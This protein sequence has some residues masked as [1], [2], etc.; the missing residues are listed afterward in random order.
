[1]KLLLAE[2]IIDSIKPKTPQTWK[3]QT[4]PNALFITNLLA[5]EPATKTG[6]PT[7]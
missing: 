4:K 5:P 6:G 2:L 3:T 1:M 7:D